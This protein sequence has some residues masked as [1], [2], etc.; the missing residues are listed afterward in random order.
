MF[1][2]VNTKLFLFRGIMLFSL[3]LLVLTISIR[4]GAMV[5]LVI[6]S[7]L[8]LFVLG[9]RFHL[10]QKDAE[11]QKQ[12]QDPDAPPDHT[13]KKPL[14]SAENSA[15]ESLPHP[16]LQP[17]EKTLPH[18]EPSEPTASDFK[19]VHSL[20]RQ[21]E[22]YLTREMNHEA[23]KILIQILALHE[24]HE[25]ALF[26]LGLIYFNEN[27][28]G[29]AET[30]LRRLSEIKETPDYLKPL[31]QVY[32]KLNE[33]E[34]AIPIYEKIV[35]TNPRE[36]ECF[37]ELGSLYL[38]LEQPEKALPYLEEAVTKT[39]QDRAYLSCLAQVAEAQNQPKKALEFWRRIA[40][41]EP[42]NDKIKQKIAELETE[43][44]D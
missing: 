6:A 4:K 44:K 2:T 19:K 15:T 16:Q 36:G 14:N 21:V 26:K 9:R 18:P 12:L 3:G 13:A 34:K 42:Y 25:E 30:V 32:Q 11:L 7:I 17:L 8:F 29:K 1:L 22:T 24:E 39:P 20:L 33:P 28:L 40:Y 35:A 41:L 10:T 37:F 5:W 23:K 31:G 43:L 38:T 27:D